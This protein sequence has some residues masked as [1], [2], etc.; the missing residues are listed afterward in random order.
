[1]QSAAEVVT[2]GKAPS[3]AEIGRASY[4][5]VPGPL[6]L[7]TLPTSGAAAPMVPFGDNRG[8]RTWS[9]AERQTLTL[10]GDIMTSTR[11]LGDDLMQAR[12]ESVSRALAA[13]SGSGVARTTWHLDGND[14]FIVRRFSCDLRTAGRETITLVSGERIDATRVTETCAYEGESFVNTYWKQTNG[15]VRRS[16]QWISPI[17]GYAEIEILRL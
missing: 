11:G 8:V 5:A 17:V 4:Q 10:R 7:I 15:T 9:T 3:P 2:P 13:G 1:M 6:I 16:R 14:R 12:V